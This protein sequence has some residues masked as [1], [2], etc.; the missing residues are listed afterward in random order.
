MSELESIYWHIWD[1]TL[2]QDHE[3]AYLHGGNAFYIFKNRGG[4]KEYAQSTIKRE[5]T[6]WQCLADPAVPNN[7]TCY[8][9]IYD[10]RYIFY[11]Q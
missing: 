7:V 3:Q 4:Y 8:S 11:L 10:A 9:E 5:W 1:V 2:E 6:P